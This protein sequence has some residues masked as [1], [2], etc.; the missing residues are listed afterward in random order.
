M[1]DVTTID[2]EYLDQLSVEQL[3]DL[4]RQLT[5]QSQRASREIQWHDAKIDKLTFEL[6]QLKR[7]QFGVKSER[8]NAEQRALFDEA[9][10]ADIATLEEQLE[11]LTKKPA[12]ADNGEKK[13]PKRAPLPPELPRVDRSHEPENTNCNCGRQMKRIGEDVSE[14]LDYTPGVFTVEVTSAASG[15][16]AIA[17]RWYKRP[18]QRP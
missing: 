4:A 8:L 1:I 13:K 17:A 15:R 14:K 3:R 11:Q 9:V 16:A 5:E 10:A 18:V 6:A 12:E 2:R 7:V